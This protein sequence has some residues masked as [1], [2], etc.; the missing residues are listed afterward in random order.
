M[1]LVAEKAW[2]VARK[3][4]IVFCLL[5]MLVG[6][7]ANLRA[8]GVGVVGGV[9]VGR[10][11]HRGSAS[12]YRSVLSPYIGAAKDLNSAAC[13]CSVE[14]ALRELALRTSCAEQTA[15]K[16]QE[17]LDAAEARLATLTAHS[18]VGTQK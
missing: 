4:A 3:K 2:V 10:F 9:G 7:L 5:Y 13:L 1:R 17:R 11:V 8:R 15:K 16:L 6:M 12:G 14:S 18:V